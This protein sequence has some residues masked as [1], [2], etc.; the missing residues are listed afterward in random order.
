M[1]PKFLSLIIFL[2][3]FNFI[4]NSNLFFQWRITDAEKKQLE[5]ETFEL[6]RTNL[7]L[8]KKIVSNY[9]TRSEELDRDITLRKLAKRDHNQCQI[10]GTAVD[11]DDFVKT[12]KSRPRSLI[13][14][15]NGYMYVTLCKNGVRK[16]HYIHRLVAEAFIGEIK[17]GYVINHLDYDRSNN[18]VENLEIVSQKDNVDYSKH[19]MKKPVIRKGNYYICDRGTRY[20]VYVK[21]KYLGSYK[22][23]EEAR[24]ARNEYINKINYY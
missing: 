19:K 17:D 15:G 16:N 20:E 24:T 11:W 6:I 14:H 23:I 21:K 1:N 9:E 13:S 2:I 7:E 22:T 5:K 8:Y 10:C 4:S 3:F 12:E 18:R